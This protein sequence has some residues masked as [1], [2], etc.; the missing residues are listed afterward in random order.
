[1]A[2]DHHVQADVVRPGELAR[3]DIELWRTLQ[4]TDT[5]LQSPFLGPS[6]A[7]LVGSLRADTRVAVIA[8]GGFF[9][10]H[11]GPGGIGAPVGRTLADYQALIAAPG[12]SWS[13]RELVLACRLRSY[14]FDH[15]L[16]AQPQWRATARLFEHSPVVRIAR[17]DPE[18]DMPSEAVR[19]ARRLDRD[20]EPRFTW[21]ETDPAALAT[22]VRWKRNQYRRTGVY[23][24]FG[25]P[26]VAE[27]AERLHAAA[28]PDLSGVL[29]C[30]RDGDDLIAAH[31]M[32]RSGPVLHSWIPAHEPLRNGQSPGLVLLRALVLEA[33]ARGIEVLDFGKGTEVYK[34]RLANDA[35]QLAAGSVQS[36]KAWRAGAA[37]ARAAVKL[38]NRTRLQGR[39]YRTSRRLQVG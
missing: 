9:A 21:H 19:K 5:A 13:A 16:V 14:T 30:L 36:R 27:L 25:H 37:A 22:L 26:W 33:P 24:V 17:F 34:A 38:A 12:L 4:Q 32:L 1:M 2:D 35:I 7:R 29:A 11:R 8:G 23:D 15:A 3:A 6:Y 20:G 31:L 39:C 10:F 18:V 28:E